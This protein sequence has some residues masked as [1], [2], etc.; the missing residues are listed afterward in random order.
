MLG[1]GLS[2]AAAELAWLDSTL[3]RL[4]QAA[5][6]PVEATEN[7]KRGFVTPTT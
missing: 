2:L 3:T 7:K 5:A 4:S 1:Y 6:L